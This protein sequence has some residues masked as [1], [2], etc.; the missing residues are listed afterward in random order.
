MIEYDEGWT[1][2]SDAPTPTQGEHS[3]LPW[4]GERINGA[5][6]LKDAED[7]SIAEVWSS[8]IDS[9][10]DA[11]AAFIVKAVNNHEKLVAALREVRQMN[12][13]IV[14]LSDKARVENARQ[15]ATQAIKAIDAALADA[16][17][18]E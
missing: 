3:P 6:L 15:Q 11:N 13:Y 5:I 18:E 10:D 17:G 8:F 12:Q 14:E 1:P 4:R 9:I 2:K 16:Q 7:H